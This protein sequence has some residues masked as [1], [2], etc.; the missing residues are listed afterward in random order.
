MQLHFGAVKKG[1]AAFRSPPGNVNKLRMFEEVSPAFTAHRLR[2]GPIGLGGILICHHAKLQRRCRDRL[3][4][5]PDH[6]NK[7]RSATSPV[8]ICMSPDRLKAYVSN[9]KDA[10]VSVVDTVTLTTTATIP[11]GASPQES[12]VTPDGKR[13]FLVHQS[14]AGVTVIDTAT[15]LVITNVVIGGNLAKDVLFT[16]DGRCAYIA[17]YSAGTVNIIDTATYRVKTIPTAAGSRRLALS[18]A[19]DRVFVTNFLGNSV[20]VIDTLTRKLIATIPV[21]NRPRGIAITPSGDTIYVTNVGDG[22]VSVIS[23]ATLTVIKTITGRSHTVACHHYA[24]RNNGIRIQ[25]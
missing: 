6:H 13:L 1:A 21:G 14:D 20:S 4:N 11:V 12:A 19:G 10:T 15:N 7:S 24:R 22:T 3:L 9:Q 16:L 23:S 2:S 18:P 5:R 17:N 25:L 8:R